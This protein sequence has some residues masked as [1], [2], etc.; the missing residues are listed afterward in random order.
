MTSMTLDLPPALRRV[1]F[2]V[3][4]QKHAFYGAPEEEPPLDG[5]P[6]EVLQQTLQI[7]KTVY[8]RDHV[9]TVRVIIGSWSISAFICVIDGR[10]LGI[11]TDL[12]VGHEFHKSLRRWMNR[13]MKNWIKLHPRL[14]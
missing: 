7:C 3:D 4:D 6:I 14:D 9:E 5:V 10:C 8:D 2:F 13:W 12:K 11:C 1:V